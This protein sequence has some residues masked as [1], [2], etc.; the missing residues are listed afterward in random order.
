MTQA[1]VVKLYPLAGV[2][3]DKYH[4][5]FSRLTVP[6]R[7]A[8]WNLLADVCEKQKALL[9]ETA[10]VEKD[11]LVK[12]LLTKE[13]CLRVAEDRI[14]ELED[15]LERF[16]PEDV[17]RLREELKMI[18]D[19]NLEAARFPNWRQIRR[20]VEIADRLTENAAESGWSEEKYY[21]E[22]AKEVYGN[23]TDERALDG[24]QDRP[25]EA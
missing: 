17:N 7:K 2:I 24:R 19:R 15:Q 11:F 20:I 6:E 13:G 1:E 4:L 5:Y 12:A 9:N 22:I 14:E 25:A 3:Y 10:Q 18:L 16:L 23:K 8:L 21:T